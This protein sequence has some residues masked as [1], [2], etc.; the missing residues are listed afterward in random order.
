MVSF[1]WV[2]APA[3][4][5]SQPI[6]ARERVTLL[7]SV[8]VISICAIIY[9][10]LIASLSSY[11]LGNSVTQFSF[12]IGL[13]LSAMGLG[14]LLSR[15]IEGAEVRWFILIE[16]IIGIAGGFSAILLYAVFALSEVYYYTAMVGIILVIGV[17]SGLEIPLLTRLTARRSELSQALSDVLSVDYLGALVA[18]LA[19]P[20]IL[21]PQLGI[22]V[23][24]LVMGLFN[25]AIAGLN[26]GLFWNRLTKAT[27]ISFAT[28]L[29][30]ASAA[31]VAGMIFS[32]ALVNLLEQQ[33]YEERIIYR[34]QTAYQRIVMTRSGSDVRLFLE[35]QLQFSSRDEYRY[36]EV[37]VHPVMSL[38][39]SHDNIAILG[40]GDGIVVRE[41]LQYADVGTITLVDLDPAMTELAKTYPIL[42]EL[43]Q[44]ALHDP[45]VVV[46]NE[47]AYEFIEHSDELFNVIIIDLP[48]P[49][50]ESL[51]K[52]YSETF[53][54]LLR[55]RLTPDG[56]FVTQATSPYFAPQAFWSIAATVEASEFEI[57]PLHSY[58]PSFGEWGFVIGTP[59]PMRPVRVPEGLTL[60]YLTPEVLDAAQVFDPDID[61][62]EVE[63]N[64]LDH[65]ILL[66]YYEDAWRQWD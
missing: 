18:S 53:Y 7:A 25:L 20:L 65:P 8:L 46:R 6:S 66:H 3:V 57:L 10:L 26:L 21:L 12:T 35:G 17:C 14:S 42:R 16:I 40:G 30:S 4:V 31:L 37:L 52:L 28:A 13:F 47:D 45:R 64:T 58:V 9:E 2:V 24:A 39:R 41:L 43:N 60:R 56:A 22:T 61:R 1:R 27:R 55:Q 29:G 38:V 51:S 50:N 34:D 63:I 48:D 62:V 15:R 49:N 54:R 32:G 44:D 59:N 33:L 19:F 23:T 36:H 11:L 5:S